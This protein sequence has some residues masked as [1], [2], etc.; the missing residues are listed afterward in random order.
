MEFWLVE[1]KKDCDSQHHFQA[2]FTVVGLTCAQSVSSFSKY[3]FLN[4]LSILKLLFII[5]HNT[6]IAY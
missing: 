5:I 3:S 2:S 4:C 6:T 1:G